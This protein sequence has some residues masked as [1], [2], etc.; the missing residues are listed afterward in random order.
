LVEFPRFSLVD[1][2]A[3][4]MEYPMGNSEKFPIRPR[5]LSEEKTR[6]KHG[7]KKGAENDLPYTYGD[8]TSSDVISCEVTIILTIH[9]KY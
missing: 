1:I 2:S 5:G 7:E 8:A 4:K 6:E 9:P 3:G